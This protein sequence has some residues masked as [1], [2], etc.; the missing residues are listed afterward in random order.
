MVTIMKRA[1]ITLALVGCAS[2]PD[3]LAGLP[4]LPIACASFASQAEA[5]TFYEANVEHWITLDTDLNG[6][7]C[8]KQDAVKRFAE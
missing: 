3:P 4:K 1:I 2:T 8:D 6:Q 7:A 5:Q